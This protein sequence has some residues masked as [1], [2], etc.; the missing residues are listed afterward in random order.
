MSAERH[1]GEQPRAGVI[2]GLTLIAS[3]ALTGLTL[4]SCLMV[5]E[6][7]ATENQNHWSALPIRFAAISL[8]WLPDRR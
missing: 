5:S 7:A 1:L 2:G 8:Q 4:L 3:A 6:Q